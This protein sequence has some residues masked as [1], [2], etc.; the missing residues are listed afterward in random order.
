M[1]KRNS[2]AK[3]AA[4]RLAV[5]KPFTL[6]CSVRRMHPDSLARLR[7]LLATEPD[8]EFA[9]LVSAYDALARLSCLPAD[10]LRAHGGRPVLDFLRAPLP[11]E[12]LGCW[13]SA[14]DLFSLSFW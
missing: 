14:A 7:A 8:L 4:G 2:S 10:P 9:V 3:S 11:I 5:L 1:D 6:T 13:T 12:P